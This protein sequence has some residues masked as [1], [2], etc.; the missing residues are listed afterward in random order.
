[1]IVD[2]D[3]SEEI[4]SAFRVI[5]YDSSEQVSEGKTSGN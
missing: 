5:L 1:M 3:T 2:R 4:G